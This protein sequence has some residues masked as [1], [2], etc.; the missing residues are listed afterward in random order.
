MS[1]Q[2]DCIQCATTERALMYAIEELKL[3]RQRD[4]EYETQ[5]SDLESTIQRL[6]S[7]VEAE[8]QR[9]LKTC[10]NA[11]KERAAILESLDREKSLLESEIAECE[12]DFRRLARTEDILRQ[13]CDAL[14]VENARLEHQAADLEQEVDRLTQLESNRAASAFGLRK[15]LQES[16]FE[17]RQLEQE[18][19][20][21]HVGT[22]QTQQQNEALLL[23]E[24][25]QMMRTR[26]IESENDAIR[27]SL[28]ETK[29]KLACKQLDE[30]C[31]M[32]P[33]ACETFGQ[34]QVR[35]LREEISKVRSDY[36]ILLNQ[37]GTG[38]CASVKVQTDTIDP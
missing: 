36:L 26:D 14:T 4:S 35:A 9:V 21:V 22:R 17:T 16:R 30:A 33:P 11:E 27:L 15:L 19:R 32:N 7:E 3:R 38:M 34:M 29:A 5:L 8:K 31:S 20:Q 18:Q 13:K 12:D 25:D 24:Q 6:Q 28:V 2:N 23:E 37:V 10:E 1:T